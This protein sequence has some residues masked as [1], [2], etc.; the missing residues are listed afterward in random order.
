MIGFATVL[1]DEYTAS[2]QTRKE[3][4]EREYFITI[5]SSPINFFRKIVYMIIHTQHCYRSL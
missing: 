2:K 3:V 5:N 1:Y 4:K